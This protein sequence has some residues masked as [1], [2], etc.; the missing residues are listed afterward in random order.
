M[1]KIV[2]DQIRLKS[3][4]EWD[5]MIAE[6][7]AEDHSDWDD[8]FVKSLAS[9]FKARGSLSSKQHDALKNVIEKWRIDT[10]YGENY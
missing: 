4:I 9:Q 1:A 7:Y 8:S 2:T 6:A 3:E 5:L 10:W